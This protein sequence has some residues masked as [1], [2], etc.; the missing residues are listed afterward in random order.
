MAKWDVL[1]RQYLKPSGYRE[2]NPPENLYV[3]EAPNADAARDSI[4]ASGQTGT[5]LSVEKSKK[6]YLTL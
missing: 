5:I 2:Q 1:M 6:S 3:V 4:R